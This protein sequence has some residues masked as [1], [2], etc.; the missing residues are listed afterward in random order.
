M[1]RRF[2]VLP[3]GV[4]FVV[5]VGGVLS[6]HTAG[7]FVPPT[8]AGQMNIPVSI[9]TIPAKC[10]GD[11]HGKSETDAPSNG[12]FE[13]HL[14]VCN[15]HGHESFFVTSSNRYLSVSRDG[16]VSTNDVTPPEGVYTI[17]G[18]NEDSN[19]SIGTWSYTLTV[20]SESGN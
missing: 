3:A 1:R 18:T 19:G 9:D 8:H 11:H 17:S 10:Q 13:D 15:A 7:N 20:T 6:A 16:T 4:I 14:K 12:H 2:L 5:A